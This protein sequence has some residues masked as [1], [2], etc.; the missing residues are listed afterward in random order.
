MEEINNKKLVS[1]EIFLTYPAQLILAQILYKRRD[2]KTLYNLVSLNHEF[3]ENLQV[4]LEQSYCS[5]LIDKKDIPPTIYDAW[6]DINGKLHSSGD[7]PSLVNI[8]DKSE[9][10]WKHG[11]RH[12]DGNKPALITSDGSKVWYIN[13]LFVSE[14]YKGI[15]I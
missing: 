3:H 14:D 8:K 12:R 11:L 6:Y 2:V 13:N 1:T 4:V 9:S 7:K 5:K 15:F 10:W